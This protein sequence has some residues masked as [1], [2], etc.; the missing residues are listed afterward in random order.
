MRDDYLVYIMMPVTAKDGV[1]WPNNYSFWAPIFWT[2]AMLQ[3]IPVN[4]RTLEAKPEGS[5]ILIP[6]PAKGR[7]PSEFRPPHNLLS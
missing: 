5:T 1:E 6:K 4:Y 2:S 3:A 7:D